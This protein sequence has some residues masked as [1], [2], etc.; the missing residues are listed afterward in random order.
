M[1]LDSYRKVCNMSPFG[2]K[3]FISQIC[4]QSANFRGNGTCQVIIP[5]STGVNLQNCQ[6]MRARDSKKHRP[7]L[8]GP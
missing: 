5:S 4:D 3:D 6:P 1:D 2:T 7:C 8:D